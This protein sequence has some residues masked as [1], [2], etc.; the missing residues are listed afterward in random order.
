M[1]VYDVNDKNK[2]P[3]AVIFKDGRIELETGMFLDYTTYGE[4]IVL[5]LMK[6]GSSP[7]EV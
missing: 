6:Q 5:K 4:Y 1:I 2:T 7:K 3:V